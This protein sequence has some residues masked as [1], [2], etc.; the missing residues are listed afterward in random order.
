MLLRA[1]QALCV[2][3]LT[4]PTCAPSL[5]QNQAPRPESATDASA[6]T[7][8]QD[9][10]LGVVTFTLDFPGS[11]PE[12]YSIRVPSEGQAHYESKGRLAPDSEETDDFAF[13]FSLS[14]GTCHRIFALAEKAGY[15]QKSL[16]SHYKNLAFT[17]K[18]TLSYQDARRSGESTYN[19]SSN[20]A[21][22]E[23]TEMFQNLSTT[24]EFGHRLDYDRRY[25]KLALDDELKRMRDMADMNSITEVEAIRPILEAIIADHSVVNVA[26][27]RA[28]QLLQNK[29]GH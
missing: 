10:N 14:S 18:K 2:I 5:G 12:H 21:A 3:V 29:A 1:F 20:S 28:Q 8:A 7:G 25:Q 27:A 23:L 4:V 26:R 15:F 16:E 13:D 17:G 9:P 24:L 11:Q 19:F 6:A 22:S